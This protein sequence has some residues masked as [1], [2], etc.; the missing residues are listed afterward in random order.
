MPTGSQLLRMT[1]VFHAFREKSKTEI[2]TPRAEIDLV[3]ER[4]GYL[5]RK[6]LPRE[7]EFDLI[8]GGGNAFGDFDDPRADLKQA[9]AILAARIIAALDEEGL[10]VREPAAR[11]GFSSADL[12]RVRNADL[13]RFTLDGL[14]ER[15][16][17]LDASLQVT[18]RSGVR[19]STEQAVPNAG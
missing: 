15:L 4:L 12:S 1:R 5:N 19:G 6:L 10:S 7:S 14:M 16:A 9:K 3:R 11:T 17:A 8:E 18:L 2:K 13:G